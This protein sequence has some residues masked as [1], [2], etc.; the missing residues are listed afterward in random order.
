MHTY[1]VIGLGNFGST[2]AKE[3]T[4]LGKEVIAVDKSMSKVDSLKGEVTHSI[5]MDAGEPGA[6][7]SLPV[8]EADAVIVCIGEDVGASVVITALAKQLKA[9]RI[10]CR[11]ISEIHD[12]ILHSIGVDLVL[13]P[14]QESANRL[15]AVIDLP[16]VERAF[17]SEGGYVFSEVKLPETWNGKTVHDIKRALGKVQLISIIRP[18]GAELHSSGQRDVEVMTRCQEESPL[19]KGDSILLMG[20]TSELKT[21]TL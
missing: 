12:T 19:R 15:A 3:L 20:R 7:N 16:N 17:W 4:V 14:E 18:L 10:L 2:L 6:M 13:R 9:K 11:A 1:I 21:L 5:C 8:K